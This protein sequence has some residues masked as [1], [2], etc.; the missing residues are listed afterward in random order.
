M[1]LPTT[2]TDERIEAAFRAAGLDT[3]HPPERVAVALPYLMQAIAEVGPLLGGYAEPLRYLAVFFRTL[4][5]E[6]D[7]EVAEG[8]VEEPTP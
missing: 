8:R 2:T 1:S 6:C 3:E 7:E 4:A 5:E